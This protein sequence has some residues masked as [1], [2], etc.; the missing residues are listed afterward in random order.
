MLTDSD[1][2]IELYP[3]FVF[4]TQHNFNANTNARVDWNDERRLLVYYQHVTGWML[5]SFVYCQ[6]QRQHAEPTF[7]NHK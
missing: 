6:Q 7:H 4:E 2:H 3:N 1:M 5:N